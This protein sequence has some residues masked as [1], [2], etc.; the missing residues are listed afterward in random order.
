PGERRGPAA[1]GGRGRHR[2][3]V[4]RKKRDQAHD[5]P[6]LDRK[7]ARKAEPGEPWPKLQPARARPCAPMQSAC[8]CVTCWTQSTQCQVEPRFE[9]EGLELYRRKE[10][11][12]RLR[13]SALVIPAVAGAHT[14]G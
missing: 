5:F 11:V 12:A 13:R 14:H 2:P 3:P 7:P 8:S 6:P 9:L 1:Q 10:L 4:V